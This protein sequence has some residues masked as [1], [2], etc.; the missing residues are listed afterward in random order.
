MATRYVIQIGK[1]Q[2]YFK[3]LRK[4]H[5]GMTI[6]VYADNSAK[7]YVRIESARKAARKILPIVGFNNPIYIKAI[8]TEKFG[9]PKTVQL[10]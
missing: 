5:V 4:K 6:W 1:G 2:L 8:D 7:K 9:M 3:S 10:I